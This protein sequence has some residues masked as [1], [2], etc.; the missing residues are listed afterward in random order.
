MSLIPI[1]NE[2]RH[3]VVAVLLAVDSDLG[4]K[5]KWCC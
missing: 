3:H 5:K 4:A 1:E 2:D